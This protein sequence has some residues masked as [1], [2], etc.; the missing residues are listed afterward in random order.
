MFCVLAS[1]MTAL[2]AFCTV[3][4]KNAVEGETTVYMPDGA[5]ALAFARLMSEDKEDDGISYFVVD[6]TT[7]ASRVTNKDE[8]KNADFCVLPLNAA[9]KLLGTGEQY[10]MLGTLTHGNLYLVAKEG[11]YASD[12]LSTLLGKT[13]GVLKINDVPGL[14]LKAVLNQYQLP[15][16]EV[17]NDGAVAADKVNLLAIAGA[18]AVGATDG[19]GK[20]LADCYMI[21]EPAA[22]A[23]KKKGYSIVGD[24]QKLYRAESDG[25]DNGENSGYKGYP[26]AV[27]V[28]K[29]EFVDEE[30]NAEFTRG[31][32]EKIAQ[33]VVWTTTASGEEIVA[34]VGGHMA[35]KNAQTSL[36]AP[37]LTSDVIARCGLR[38]AYAA[39]N[40]EEVN[41]FLTDLIAVNN[42]AAKMPAEAFFWTETRD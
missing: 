19:E 30:E 31:F 33:S 2:A 10:A 40:K 24:L 18:D 7:I 26:Q 37:L 36:K 3:G 38:F 12:N 34:A 4:C 14:T 11:E 5:P 25:G 29:R 8:E 1:V 32:V 39:E 22:T 17:G 15:W 20:P 21:A 42:K 13:V 16:Q 6:P 23:Q 28:A 9:S 27:L 41:G 35:D